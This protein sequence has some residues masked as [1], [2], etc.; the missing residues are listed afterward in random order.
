MS[1]EVT[2]DHLLWHCWLG[3]LTRRNPVPDMSYN[4][5]GGTLNL[6]QLSLSG[7]KF[8]LGGIC[9]GEQ[10]AG[11]TSRTLYRTAS[12]HMQWL[13]FVTRWLTHRQTHTQRKHRQTESFCLEILLAKPAEIKKNIQCALLH[14]LLIF[15]LV[16]SIL[17][18]SCR[19]HITVSVFS[20]L[21]SMLLSSLITSITEPGSCHSF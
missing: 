10:P 12:L 17:H 6:T 13:W 7:G 9:P 21:R 2:R 19:C 20:L 15:F 8:P 5:F 4:V 3:L 11:E 1:G 18:F 14:E 16:F